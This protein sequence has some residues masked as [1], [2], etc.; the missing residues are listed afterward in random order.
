MQDDLYILLFPNFGERTD[1]RRDRFWV[2]Q[3]F[4]CRAS[5]RISYSRRCNDCCARL[6]IQNT[7]Y[8]RVVLGKV[9]IGRP[10]PLG[11]RAVQDG[12]G[13]IEDIAQISGHGEGPWVVVPADQNPGAFAKVAIRHI[14]AILNVEL[15]I[16]TH[17][18]RHDFYGGCDIDFSV[19]LMAEPLSDCRVFG[20]Q[21]LEAVQN[22]HNLHRAVGSADNHNSLNIIYVDDFE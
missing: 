2:G 8:D 19:L 6:G 9:R 14:V 18:H 21:R 13:P 17:Q 5:S 16:A 1:Q 11:V 20:V 22:M 10:A 4:S 15:L 12:R 7:G 3:K